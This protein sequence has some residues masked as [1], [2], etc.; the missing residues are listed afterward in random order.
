LTK[1]AYRWGSFRFGKDGINLPEA[2]FT[3]QDLPA[4][5]LKHLTVRIARED[6]RVWA[7]ELLERDHYLGELSPGSMLMQVRS[8]K[9]AGLLCWTGERR[10][11][12]SPS[13]MNGSVGLLS[14]AA[15]RVPKGKCLQFC[16]SRDSLMFDELML[17]GIRPS[18][19]MEK[20]FNAP[21]QLRNRGHC[22]GSE[23][24]NHWRRDA[25]FEEGKTRSKNS[26]INA[27][28]AILRAIL[29]ALK[30]FPAPDTCV[31]AEF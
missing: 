27:N 5:L 20:R 23:S 30:S 8:M 29:I 2:L 15:E 19:S 28:L 10:R 9:D 22:N 24:N 13:G 18:N 7:N 31:Q 6:E 21:L 16:V 12:S 4:F 1:K 26:R 11:T 17:C 14:S 3:T 25:L